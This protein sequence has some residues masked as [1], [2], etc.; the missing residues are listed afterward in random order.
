[1]WK[2]IASELDVKEDRVGAVIE[3]LS[4]GARLLVLD[5]LEQLE[6]APEVV[7]ELLAGAPGLVVLATSRRPL[8]VQGEHEWPVWPLPVP[9]VPDMTLEQIE[10]SAA[11]RLFLQQ[12]NLVKPNFALTPGN[13]A[14]VA[15]ICRRLDG[16]PLAIE[17]AAAR[18]K[19]L[20]PRALRSRLGKSLGLWAG[21]AWRPLRQ[22]TL[23]N[24]IAWSYDLLTPGLQEIFRRIGVF[25]GGCE[26][27]AFAAVTLAGDGTGPGADALRWVS[28]LADL[29]LVT[30]SEGADGEPRSCCSR[31]FADTP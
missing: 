14:D 17:L 10:A 2:T 5:N 7:A 24:T 18:V 26:L 11:V 15:A 31:R 19:L 28:E 16:L 9:A 12:A 8:H 23:R 29:S 27:D 22:Q 6:E 30:V 4:T 21:D 1:M 13:A 3:Y 25:E 20:T